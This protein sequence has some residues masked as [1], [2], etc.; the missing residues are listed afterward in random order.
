MQ[1]LSWTAPREAKA[2][3][4]EQFVP[5]APLAVFATGYTH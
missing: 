3:D 4:A 5:F 2:Y 1:I